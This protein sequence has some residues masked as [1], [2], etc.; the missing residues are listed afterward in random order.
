MRLRESLG[1]QSG[2][3]EAFGRQADDPPREHGFQSLRFSKR[4]Q[5][6][7]LGGVSP[8]PFFSRRRR[9][10]KELPHRVSETS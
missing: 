7:A 6:A 10:Q 8:A 3:Y 1:D 2:Q 5:G 9:R 4:V